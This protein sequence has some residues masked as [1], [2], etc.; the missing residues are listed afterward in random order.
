[1][2]LNPYPSVKF[3]IFNVLQSNCLTKLFIDILPHIDYLMIDLLLAISIK[4]AIYVVFIFF[5]LKLFSSLC[6]LDMLSGLLIELIDEAKLYYALF[7]P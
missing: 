7:L 6:L 3:S 5:I 4:D 1:M 2:I